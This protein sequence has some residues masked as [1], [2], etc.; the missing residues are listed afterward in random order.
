MNMRNATC[1]RTQTSKDPTRVALLFISYSM[2]K[3]NIN[4]EHTPQAQ[5]QRLIPYHIPEKVKTTLKD[6]EKQDIIEKVLGPAHAMGIP[7]NCSTKE[8]Q[9]GE[10]PYMCRCE[11][12]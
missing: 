8:R 7:N 4:K 11:T 9:H 5:P 3:L 10:G 1:V 12:C 6:L 2:V